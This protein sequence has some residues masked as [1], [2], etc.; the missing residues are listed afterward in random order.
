MS[1]RSAAIGLASASSGLP[2][3]NS[4]A[5]SWETNDQVTAS[6]KPKLASARF[7]ARVRFCNSVSTGLGTPASSRGSGCIG[8]RST[9]AMR[10]ICSTM[11]ALPSMSGRQLGTL[12]TPSLK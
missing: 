5:W 10:T 8:T 9:P 12:T 4:F 1:E 11:S 3:P 6:L 2:P 7:A